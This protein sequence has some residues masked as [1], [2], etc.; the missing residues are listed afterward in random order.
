MA[1]GA[2]VVWSVG[3]VLSSSADGADTFQYLVWRSIGIVAVI[4]VLGVVR[5]RPGQLVRAFTSG[6]AML[7]A[8]VMM[9][10][11]SMGFVYAVKTTT[12]ANAA[13][14]ASTTP[15]FGALAARVLLRERLDRITI[16]S[17]ALAFAGLAV[18][19]A[20]DLQAGNMAG[21]LAALAAA[22][23]FALYTVCVRSDPHLDWHPVLPGYGALMILVC[24]AV[25]IAQGHTLVPPAVDVTYALVHGAVVITVGTVLY[26][27]S[28]RQVPAAAMT[29]F[30]QSEM[31]LV[32]VWG[33]AFLGERPRAT[34]VVG[35]VIVLVAIVGRAVLATRR[36]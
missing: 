8:N 35:G 26:N 16:A 18:M 11:A 27:V 30:A 12:A 25:V 28:S 29:V 4:E 21:N 23:G 24:G 15:V 19:V 5:R 7:A 6:R 31:V 20:G 13:F 1:L 36:A 3:A 17:I 2:G 34:T 32:P 33:I 14:L 10:V 22:V 9:V